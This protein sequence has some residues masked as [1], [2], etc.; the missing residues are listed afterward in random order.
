MA[1]QVNSVPSSDTIIP[2]L[3]RR[4]RS[5]CGP[6]AAPRAT[7]PEWR[8]GIPGAPDDGTLRVQYAHSMVDP[9]FS[10]KKRGEGEEQSLPRVQHALPG[11]LNSNCNRL[12]NRGKARR[13]LDL[14]RAEP[15]LSQRHF[16]RIHAGAPAI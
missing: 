14:R 15:C 11:C 13:R 3:P 9:T 7:S 1:L 16:M 2:G 4:L 5:V 10:R 8:P 12:H 6:P